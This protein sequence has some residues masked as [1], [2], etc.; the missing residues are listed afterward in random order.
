[1]SILK[2]TDYARK[3]NINYTFHQIFF[4][5]LIPRARNSAV[6][7]FLNDEESTHL[8]FIDS[9]I[10]FE[11]EHIKTLL[12][13]DKE[14]ISGIYPKKFID[15][16]RVKNNPR[17][18]PVN[19]PMGGNIKLTEDNLIE[20]DFIPS[21]FLSIKK[22]A[23]IKLVNHYPELKYKNYVDKYQGANHYFYNLFKTGVEN[24]SYQS[25]DWGFCNLWRGLGGKL[26]IHPDVNVKHIGWN[27]YEG[28]IFKHLVETDAI[29][30][31]T[32]IKKENY[33]KDA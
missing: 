16:E 30:I 15:W 33:L 23:I 18:E 6:A 21:G 29:S 12:N 8:L 22:E 3:E 26:Y 7:H 1:M 2:F 32:L 25:E 10:I 20:L 19:F 17:L 24:G 13:S 27:N 4:E 5:S 14:I 9:D 31:K 11:P 28:K